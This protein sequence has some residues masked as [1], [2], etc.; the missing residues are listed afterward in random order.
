MGEI[1]LRTEGG[2]SLPVYLSISLLQVSG[3]P[4][5]WCLVVTDLTE[6]KKNEEIVAAGRLARSIIEQAAEGIV[7]CDTSGKITHFSNTITRI[8]ECDPTFHRFEDI[9]DLQFSEPTAKRLKKTQ[10]NRRNC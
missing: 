6:Q 1:N 9:M 5:A 8:C 2:M 7:V 3:S 4:N 10:R